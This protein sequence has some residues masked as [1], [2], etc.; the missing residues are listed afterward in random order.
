[1]SL[2]IV[3]AITLLPIGVHAGVDVA[4]SKPMTLFL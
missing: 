1:M 3:L 4:V 2:F